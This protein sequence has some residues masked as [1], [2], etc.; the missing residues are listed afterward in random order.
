MRSVGETSTRFPQGCNRPGDP[1]AGALLPLEGLMR[2]FN[3]KGEAY[4]QNFEFICI[5]EICN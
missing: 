1:A 4:H 5:N 2:W 3:A